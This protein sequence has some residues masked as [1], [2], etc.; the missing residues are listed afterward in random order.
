MKK[1]DA[2]LSYLTAE[3]QELRAKPREDRPKCVGGCY[4]LVVNIT[5]DENRWRCWNCLRYVVH[6]LSPRLF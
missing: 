5:D 1:A 4:L 2:G 3:S 6:E